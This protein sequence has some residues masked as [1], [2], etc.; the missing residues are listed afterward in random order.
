MKARRKKE[1]NSWKENTYDNTQKERASTNTHPHPHDHHPN[2]AILRLDEQISEFVNGKLGETLS[3]ID[4]V[5][6]PEKITKQHISDIGPGV[7]VSN[8]KK[9]L[10]TS[11]V[12]PRQSEVRYGCGTW[13]RAM[14]YPLHVCACVQQG[15]QSQPHQERFHRST[16]QSKH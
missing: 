12:V 6:D 10:L 5:Q 11:F 14:V 3:I 1:S 7:L 16:P 13:P 2:E 8:E 4:T 15:T 9:K